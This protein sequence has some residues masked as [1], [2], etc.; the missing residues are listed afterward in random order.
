M[1]A[2]VDITGKR[3]G[4]LVALFPISVKPRYWALKCDCGGFTKA[5]AGDFNRGGI[6]SC[7][8]RCGSALRTH[9]LSQTRL[10]S[11]WLS[12]K[13]RCFNEKHPRFHR[14]GGRG[15]LIC[16]DWL[17][18]ENFATWALA[19]GYADNLQIDRIDNNG[20]YHPENCRFVTPKENMANRECSK[21]A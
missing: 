3:Q 7:S 20:H 10:Y 21:H 14:Y 8:M 19:N 12:M 5:T 15:I 1:T 4:K 6:K 16:F 18:F 2:K 17:N 9:G 11:V 13:D